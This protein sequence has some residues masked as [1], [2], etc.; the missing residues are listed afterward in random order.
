M[1][2]S[3]SSAL[4]I[5]HLKSFGYMSAYVCICSVFYVCISIF[6]YMYMYIYMCV[7][8]HVLICACTRLSVLAFYSCA[9]LPSYTYACLLVLYMHACLLV[10]YMS[11]RLMSYVL[12]LIYVYMPIHICQSYIRAS[13][14]CVHTCQPYISHII[15]MCKLFASVNFI[16][17]RTQESNGIT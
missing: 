1:A 6:L 14:V 4:S 10:L 8:V 15:Y 17:L 2:L 5:S 3:V 11:I 16:R 9:Y 7:C 12:C 13:S